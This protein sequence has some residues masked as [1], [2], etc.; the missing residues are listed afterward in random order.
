MIYLLKQFLRW[1]L[2]NVMYMLLYPIAML[3]IFL[4]I[5]G[6]FYYGF[7]IYSYIR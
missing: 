3:T 2:V 1:V 5:F 6:L 7:V 4:I